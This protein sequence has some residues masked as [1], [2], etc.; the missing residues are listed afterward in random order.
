MDIINYAHFLE[1]KP[2]IA[3]LCLYLVFVVIHFLSEPLRWNLYLSFP[4]SSIK[5]L[6]QIFSLTAFSTYILPLK[7]GLPLRLWLLKSHTSQS[8]STLTGLMLFDGLLYYCM[9][10]ISVL[11]T[12]PGI[13]HIIHNNLIPYRTLVLS[14]IFF[15]VFTLTILF[16]LARKTRSA[17]SPHNATKAS[18][19][20]Q[21]R[22][23]LVN[24]SKQ[25]RLLGKKT[26][27]L[28]IVICTID[29]L[30]HVFRHW[31]LLT[32]LGQDIALP[33][34]AA[35]SCLSLFAG[36]ITMMPMGLGGY[37]VTLVLL[38]TQ[39]GVSSEIAVAIPVLNRLG[40]IMVS[41]LLGVW[42]GWKLGINPIVEHK[43]LKKRL[44]NFRSLI[45]PQK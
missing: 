8:I 37:D 45:S 22:K 17:A 38:L 24:F 15:F 19:I 32:F 11:I 20:S 28:G 40:N 25:S 1:E 35:I 41:T 34:I 9:W 33:V 18:R 10:G 21:L 13:Q 4:S 27:I 36:L 7:L 44:D 29:I 39:V 43:L 26:V 6:T 42:G 31:A 2:A 3:S 23:L 30:S 5:L 14:V 16:F 12:L